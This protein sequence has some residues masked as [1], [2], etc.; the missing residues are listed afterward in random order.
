LE[1]S[2]CGILIL[3]FENPGLETGFSLRVICAIGAALTERFNNSLKRG[4]LVLK[5]LK[6]YE[7]ILNLFCRINYKYPTLI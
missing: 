4:L 5:L 3:N 2:P 1:T 6:K 7:N